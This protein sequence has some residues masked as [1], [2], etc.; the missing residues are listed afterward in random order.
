MWLGVKGR[1]EWDKFLVMGG[2]SCLWKR[3]VGLGKRV[4]VIDGDYFGNKRNDGEIFGGVIN[5]GDEGVVLKG[6]ERIVEGIIWWYDKVDY[7]DRRDE[8]GGGFGCRGN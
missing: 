6:G 3:K 7:D 4:G 5:F 1:V 2:R 8:G